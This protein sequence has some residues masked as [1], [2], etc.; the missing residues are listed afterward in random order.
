MRAGLVAAGTNPMTIVDLEGN[1]DAGL[2]LVVAGLTHDVR[3]ALCVIKM[4]G[5]LVRRYRPASLSQVEQNALPAEPRS[6]PSCAA[7]RIGGAR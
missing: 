3:G 1:H 2:E 4:L 5:A 6:A 7:L